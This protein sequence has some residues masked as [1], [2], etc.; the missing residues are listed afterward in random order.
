MGYE[1]NNPVLFMSIPK[2]LRADARIT[3]ALE[4]NSR[5]FVTHY[6]VYATLIEVAKMSSIR[7]PENTAIHGRNLFQEVPDRDCFEMGISPAYCLCRFD[8]DPLSPQDP[9]IPRIVNQI[10]EDANQGLIPFQKNCLLHELDPDFAPKVSKV[11][12]P[13]SQNFDVF[14][15]TFQ[16]KYFVK[17]GRWWTFVYLDPE[18]NVT[19]NMLQFGHRID[20]HGAGARCEGDKIDHCYCKRK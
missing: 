4:A 19:R 6:D 15:V 12:I 11:A 17:S 18:R 7:I 8:E 3:A 20:P 13:N 2:A 1:D 16:T 5:K 9:L 10:I 14:K